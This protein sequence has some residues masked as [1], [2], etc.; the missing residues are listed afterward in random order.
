MPYVQKGQA[1][2]GHNMVCIAPQ[3]YDEVHSG[4]EDAEMRVNTQIGPLKST[5]MMNR[6]DELQDMRDD[7]YE[8]SSSTPRCSTL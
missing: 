1:M 2:E 3:S 4:G 6:G 7:I 5:M 8:R